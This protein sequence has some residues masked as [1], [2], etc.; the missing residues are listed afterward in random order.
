AARL[1]NVRARIRAAAGRAG[2]DASDVVLV[3]AT[4]TVPVDRIA[5]AVEAGLCDLGCNRAQ[6]LKAK[7]GSVP[8]EVRWHYLGPVQTNKVRYLDGVHL[9]HALCRAT[10][11]RVLQAR[12]ERIG[13]AW[14]VLVEV[15]VAGE[16][17]KH[18]IAPDDMDEL[19]S[20][21]ASYPLVTPRGVMIVAPQVEN[22]E[23]VR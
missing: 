9:I 13:R 21:I 15:N 22:H 6:D 10:E 16:T 23:D 19:L 5:E 2:R 14:D 1:D 3:G 18:G 4:K 20:A 11:A 8:G 7:A 12:G 17:S